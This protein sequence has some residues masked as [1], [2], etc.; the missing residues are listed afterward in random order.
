[1]GCAGPDY[2]YSVYEKHPE[3]IKEC[4]ALG[5]KVNVWT[6][7]KPS[8]MEWCIKHDID[9]ITTNEPVELQKMI[10]KE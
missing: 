3:W 7:N 2:Q 9:F 4:H 6:V 1:M 8:A 5:L 10:S